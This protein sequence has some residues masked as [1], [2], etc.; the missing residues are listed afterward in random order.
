M[1]MNFAYEVYFFTP[2]GFLTC[3][4]ILQGTESFTSPPKEVVVRILIAF[5]NPLSSARFQPAKLGSN[6]K[7]AS[8]RTQSA[9][10][11]CDK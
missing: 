10:Y 1:V 11:E 5:K 6:S 9:T 3:C 4:K 2:V 7:H 8:T